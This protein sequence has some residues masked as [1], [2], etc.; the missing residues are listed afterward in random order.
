MVVVRSLSLK[1]AQAILGNSIH[2]ISWEMFSVQLNISPV[3][4]WRYER[5]G[6]GRHSI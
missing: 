3:F 2:F 5:V 1:K 6:I 4:F